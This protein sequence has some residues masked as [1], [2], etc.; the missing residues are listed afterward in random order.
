MSI[1]INPAHTR[2]VT[3]AVPAVTEEVP[4]SVTVTLT[5]FEA[6]LVASLYGSTSGVRQV[7]PNLD[8][9]WGRFHETNAYEAL[10]A[11]RH[12]TARFDI[13]DEF[14]ESLGDILEGVK[15]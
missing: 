3:P 15:A 13:G 8:L 14:V 4:G 11:R 6:L 5:P 2:E 10:R 9:L 12:D 1:Q 7:L